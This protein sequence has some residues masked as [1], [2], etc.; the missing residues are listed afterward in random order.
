[1]KSNIWSEIRSNFEDE[2]I[3]HIDAWVSPDDDEEGK[4][5]ATINKA[6]GK[7]SYRDE[8][9]RTDVYAQETIKLALAENFTDEEIREFKKNWGQSHSELCSELGYSKRDSDD[10]IML[11]FFWIEEDKKWYNKC[12]SLFTEREQAIADYL[13]TR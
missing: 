9:A 4:V 10:I 3:I 7:V 11:D 6:T 1:M 12:A 8:R 5:I 2:G 13:R